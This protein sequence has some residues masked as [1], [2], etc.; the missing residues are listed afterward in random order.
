MTTLD[1][2]DGVSAEVSEN[3]AD[4]SRPDLSLVPP[5]LEQLRETWL[6]DYMLKERNL[7]EATSRSYDFGARVLERFTGKPIFLCDEQDYR[8]YVRTSYHSDQHKGTVL[9]AF[10][11]ARRFYCLE[12]GTPWDKVSALAG[13]RVVQE[14][15][16]PVTL[17]LAQ[18]LLE[19]ASHPLEKRL[20]FLSL[21][22]STRICE[23]CDGESPHRRGVVDWSTDNGGILI[24][25]KGRKF[26]ENPIHP[27]LAEV[28]DE[29]RSTPCLS[30][31]KLEYRTQ[32]LKAK[33]NDYFHAHMLRARFSRQFEELR[34]P[35]HD[36]RALAA[37]MG[38]T[39]QTSMTDKYSGGVMFDRKTELML[40]LSYA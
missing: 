2:I 12:T 9:S 13:P 10:K 36:E 24:Y 8:L 38:H 32:T 39:S 6:T 29:I 31:R 22:C 35:H 5:T 17:E 3:G 16:E 37:M 27:A 1:R 28:L 4:P 30:R 11:S 18:A 15:V 20:V 34:N 25:G 21:Y 14:E 23:A 7:A 26:R 40:R 19:A 33:V